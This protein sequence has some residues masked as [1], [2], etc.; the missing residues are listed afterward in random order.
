[1]KIG[2]KVFAV[3]VLPLCTALSAPTC[4]ATFDWNLLSDFNNG[5]FGQNEADGYSH[6]GWS[7]LVSAS[8]APGGQSGSAVTCLGGF[9]GCVPVVLGGGVIMHDPGPNGES[10]GPMI[11]HDPG[12]DLGPNIITDPGPGLGPMIITNTSFALMQ[13][14][15]GST[16]GPVIMQEPGSALMPAPD[17]LPLFAG[18]L[19]LL[20]FLG[21]CRKRKAPAGAA[22]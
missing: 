9:S 15:L 12:P 21:L 7:S 19:G 4:A 1:M 10:V 11:M 5:F 8:T 17:S 18:G 20:G 3:G 14:P 16:L 13:A 22:V 2:L 6:G